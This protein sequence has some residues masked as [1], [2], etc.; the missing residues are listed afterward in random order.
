MKRA[1][2]PISLQRSTAKTIGIVNSLIESYVAQG[3]RMSVRQVY[4]QM[5]ARGAIEN[6]LQSYKR[7]ADLLNNARLGGITDWDAI[8]DRNREITGR[9]SWASGQSVLDSAAASF[10][11]DLWDNQDHRVFIVIEKAAL[12]GVMESV[13]YDFDIPLLA[14]RGFPSV[15]IVREMALG[16][17]APAIDTGQRVLLLHLGDHDPSG[18]DMTRDLEDRFNLFLDAEGYDLEMFRLE[19]IALNMEQI[20]ELDPP[21]NPAKVTDSRYAAYKKL[22]G[23]ESWE[24]DALDP[25]Y[26]RDLITGFVEPLIDQD[27]LAETKARIDETKSRLRKVA[28]DWDKPPPAPPPHPIPPHSDDGDYLF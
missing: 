27:K 10:H 11:M 2:V 23:E 12:L 13:C 15:S 3:L 22:Y 5:V 26:L 24:L 21:P 19:R 6:T 14:A 25:T 20:E 28:E 17:V 1:Y 18:I 4:Y 8:E 16:H 9:P 7:L